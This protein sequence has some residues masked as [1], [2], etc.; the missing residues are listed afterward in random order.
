MR[1]ATTVFWGVLWTVVV[2]LGT[3]F[4]M[5][6]GGIEFFQN[7][8]GSD[9]NSQQTPI[10]EEYHQVSSTNQSG[11]ITAH[12]IN[13]R[14]SARHINQRLKAQINGLIPADKSEKI[15]V[16]SSLNDSEAFAFAKEIKDYLV[17]QGRNV[18]GVNQVITI[19]PAVGQDAYR[20]ENGVFNIRVGSRE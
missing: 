13:A 4:G 2:S 14:K 3:I 7:V 10:I 16:S 9:N 11:G 19:P 18:E 15:I 17:S 6:N 1:K 12:T 5:L 8:F 20:D